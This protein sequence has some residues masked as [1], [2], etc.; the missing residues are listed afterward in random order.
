M[1]NSFLSLCL[2]NSCR[3][4]I[5]SASKRREHLLRVHKFISSPFPREVEPGVVVESGSYSFMNPLSIC[6]PHK[7]SDR[8]YPLKCLAAWYGT[9]IN[10][11]AQFPHSEQS[12]FTPTIKSDLRKELSLRPSDPWHIRDPP[13][14]E[15]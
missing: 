7:F 6:R 3:L 11:H 13:A 9:R 2:P 1:R 8:V 4:P 15:S 5:Y 12:C 10:L 14:E